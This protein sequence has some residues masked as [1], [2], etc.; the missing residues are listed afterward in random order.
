M[1][2]K[3]AIEFEQVVEI[4][5]GADVHKDIIVVT[6]LGKDTKPET[7]SYKTYTSSLI[8][9]REWLLSKRVT[10]M[11][12]ESTGVYW[13]PVFNVMGDEIKILLVNARHVKNVPGHKTDK[14]DSQWLAKLL[15]SGLLKGSFIPERPIRELRDLTRYKTNLIQMISSERNRFMKTLEDANIKLSSVLNDVFGVTGTKIMNHVLVFENYRP[16]EL[17]QYVHGKVK[18]PRPEIMEALTGYITPHHRF[19]LKTILENISQIERTIRTVEAHIE[20]CIEP[21]KV[22]RELLETIPGV[23]KESANRIIAEIGVDMSQFPDQN[24]LA[25]WAGVC[26][27]SNET[28][29]KNKSG[30]ITHGNKYLRSLL[31][32]SGWAASRTKN[33][34]MSAKYKSLVGR[35]GKKKAIIALGH[36]ILIATYFI[37]RDKVQFKELGEDHLNNYRKDRLIAYYQKQLEKLTAA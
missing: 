16:E 20:A 14:G 29:G 31:V 27:G 32:E 36:K 7:R 30:R 33:T 3:N 12:M 11:A 24:H 4:G 35:R 17:I 23:H 5:C 8:K 13:K 2:E 10:H 26:P 18:A 19:M 1:K 25:S 21:Y 15:L 22:E 9:L 28:A 34:Y 37:L 6:V